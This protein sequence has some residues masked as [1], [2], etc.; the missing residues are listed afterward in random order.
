ME[1]ADEGEEV[2]GHRRGLSRRQVC[3]RL[4]G[5]VHL[6]RGSSQGTFLSCLATT[7]FCVAGTSFHSTLKKENKRNIL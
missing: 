3:W 2:K 5:F 7:S 1:K 4:R 6:Q